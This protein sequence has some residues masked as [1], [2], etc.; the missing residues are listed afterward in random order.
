MGE[1]LDLWASLQAGIPASHSVSPASAE[2]RTMTATSGLRCIE[3]STSSGRL[4]LLERMLLG[5]SRWAST[6]CFLTWSEVVTPA[7][8][9]LYRLS[10]S[11]PDTAESGYGL[12]P[13]PTKESY[14]TTNNGQHGDGSVY[15]TAGKPS[16][17][18]MAR[19]NLWPTPNVPNGG[20]T[21]HH[22]EFRGRTAIDPKTGKKVQF[23][24]E[25]AVKMYPTPRSS[26]ADKGIRTPEGAAR[27]RERRK[28]GEDLPSRVGGSLNPTWVEWLM[29]Y[30]LEHTVCA[31]WE[32]QSSRKSRRKSSVQSI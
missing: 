1:Q 11:M 25:A 16:L 3:S 31:L 30:P 23:G 22:A 14:G 13:T 15:K 2:A 10:P 20:R 27:E 18:T 12:L 19:H 24:L 5:T 9:L 21:L 32:T 28:N 17:E 7:G 29:G 6:T 26:D 8:R 4:G